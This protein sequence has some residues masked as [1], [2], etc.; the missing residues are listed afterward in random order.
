MQELECL[1]KSSLGEAPGVYSETMRDA[2]LKK[3]LSTFS[4][5]SRRSRSPAPSD[6]AN[7]PEPG[8]ERDPTRLI[9]NTVWECHNCGKPVKVGLVGQSNYDAHV[10]SKDCV[11]EDNIDIVQLLLEHNADLNIV[12]GNYGTALQAAV[13]EENIDIVQLLQAHGAM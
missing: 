9:S 4:L 5:S 2:E 7:E 3:H 6:E 8:P 13:C 1:A 12:G 10:D 11:K